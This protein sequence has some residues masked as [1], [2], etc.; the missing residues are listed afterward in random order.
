MTFIL[1]NKKTEVEI[2]SAYLE[3]E[4]SIKIKQAEG[5]TEAAFMLKIL[6]ESSMFEGITLAFNMLICGDHSH[7]FKRFF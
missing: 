3:T 1:Y 2:R 7:A 6:L 5:M 4:Y